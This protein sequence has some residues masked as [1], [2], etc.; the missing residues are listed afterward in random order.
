MKNMLLQPVQY[1]VEKTAWGIWR[2][3]MSEQGAY[4][5]EFRSHAELLGLPLLH[6]TCGISPE[7]G[8]RVVAKGVIAVGR[9]AVGG[10]AIGQ[11]SLGIIALGQAGFGLLAGLGQLST[12]LYAV[13]Q[14]ALGGVFGIGQLAT[15]T[16][17]IGQLALGEYVLAQLGI[18]HY[19]WTPEQQDAQAVEHFTLLWQQ[20]K[21]LFQP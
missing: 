11:A 13:G 14:A 1:K 5:S 7:T 3:H 10:L 15:G 4:F 19:L 12:G 6:Y 8:R 2:S 18:G 20:V 9:L 17:A 21:A 16:T